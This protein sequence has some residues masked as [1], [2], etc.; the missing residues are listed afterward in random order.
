MESQ[1]KDPSLHHR[2]HGR[3]G[4]ADQH[5]SINN[6]GKDGDPDAKPKTR[7]LSH[8]TP[9]NQFHMEKGLKEKAKLRVFKKGAHSCGQKTCH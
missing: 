1:E 2:G 6:A 4:I 7:L 3:G 5:R 9:R 8:T